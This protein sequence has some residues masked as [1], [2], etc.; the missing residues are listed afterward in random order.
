MPAFLRQQLPAYFGTASL[1]AGGF[2]GVAKAIAHAHRTIE[3]ALLSQSPTG[4]RE[5]T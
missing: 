2:T 4:Q 3:R 1:S 5:A